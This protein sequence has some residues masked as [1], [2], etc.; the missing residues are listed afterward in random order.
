MENL[1]MLGALCMCLMFWFVFQRAKIQNYLAEVLKLAPFL[2]SFRT[3]CPILYAALSA[4][5][6]T[7]TLKTSS[8]PSFLNST[9]FQTSLVF[10]KQC[11][12][13]KKTRFYFAC[14]KLLL[15][16]NL[17]MERHHISSIHETTWV[18]VACETVVPIVTTKYFENH[19]VVFS[20]VGF[21]Y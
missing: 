19:L 20:F 13:T 6:C 2:Q 7:T 11:L 21:S 4:D 17:F 18:E 5:K 9:A 14:G 16:V 1:E 3:K 8:F 10:M 12:L 15:Q